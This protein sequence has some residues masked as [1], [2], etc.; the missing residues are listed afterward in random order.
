MKPEAT[1]FGAL[2][3]RLLKIT[4]VTGER[5]IVAIAGP[6]GSGKT[7]LSQQLETVLNQKQPNLAAVVQMDGFHF[8]DGLLK[9]LGRLQ[10]KGAPDTFD[11]YGLI[12]LLDRL[13]RNT[14]AFVLAPMFDR[15]LE[16][17]RAAAK[18][19][20]QKTQLII[21]EGLYLLL[22]ANPWSLL[23]QYFDLSV[24]MNVTQA[25]LRQRLE[26]RWQSHGYNEAQIKEKV[27]GNDMPNAR[28]IIAESRPPDLV[29]G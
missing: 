24:N 16:I 1:D 26:Q 8:D 17:S 5:K 13:K 6:P 14:E 28:F 3:Q 4:L 20:D 21:V 7:T 19:V 18:R 27:D 25:E 12:S 23:K 29:F 11:V 15:D 22:N 10:H 9:S 2:E